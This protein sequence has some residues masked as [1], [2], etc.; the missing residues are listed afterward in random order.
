MAHYVLI[1]SADSTQSLEDEANE[2]VTI[3][4]LKIPQANWQAAQQEL[5]SIGSTKSVYSTTLS[6]ESGSADSIVLPPDAF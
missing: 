2:I 4:A 5:N 6:E 1:E 3:K